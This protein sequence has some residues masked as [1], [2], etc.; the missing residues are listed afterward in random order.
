MLWNAFEV[1]P[2]IDLLMKQKTK[3][4]VWQTPLFWLLTNHRSPPPSIQL[5]IQEL[6]AGAFLPPRFRRFTLH[7]MC[8]WR[9]EETIQEV[10]RTSVARIRHKNKFGSWV[11]SIP[12]HNNC[13]AKRNQT[14]RCQALPSCISMSFLSTPATKNG[15]CQPLSAFARRPAVGN[16]TFVVGRDHCYLACQ[17]WTWRL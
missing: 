3:H 1:C 15:Q 9:G 5:C 17:D 2:V 14:Y 6:A 8:L 12:L 13:L 10:L 4:S 7:I 16:H 11:V